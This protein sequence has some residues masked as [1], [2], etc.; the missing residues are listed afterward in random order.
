MNCPKCGTNFKQKYLSRHTIEEYEC[1]IWPHCGSYIVIEED[2][3]ARGVLTDEI[4]KR[5][6]ISG[7]KK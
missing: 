5:N 1:V 3:I 6:G 4:L 2:G 7:G